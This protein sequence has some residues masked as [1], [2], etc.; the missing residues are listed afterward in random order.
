LSQAKEFRNKQTSE[1]IDQLFDKN[2]NAIAKEHQ[3]SPANEYQRLLS[4]LYSIENSK[5]HGEFVN[6]MGIAPKSGQYALK[7]LEDEC[8]SIIV[9]LM[10]NASI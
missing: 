2:P 7:A 6:L 10:D 1:W 3:K 8:H 5:V 9:Q 4:E